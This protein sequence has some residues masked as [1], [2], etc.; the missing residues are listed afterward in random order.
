MT[1]FDDTYRGAR[2]T[3]GL[4]FRPLSYG[5]VPPG[6]IVFSDRE[7]PDYPFGTV[8][9]PVDLGEKAESMDMVLL[10]KVVILS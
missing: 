10:K 4:K 9:Y 6:W 7:H 5:N 8:D 2:W 1:L 3:Y